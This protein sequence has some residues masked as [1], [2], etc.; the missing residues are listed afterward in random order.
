MKK[1]FPKIIAIVMVFAMALQFA[2]A[3]LAATATGTE[4]WTSGSY[5]YIAVFKKF[6]TT[7]TCAFKIT[8]TETHHNMGR[9]NTISGSYRVNTYGDTNFPSAYRNKLV[10]AAAKTGITLPYNHIEILDQYTIPASF[11]SGTYG[12][13]VTMIGQRGEYSVQKSYME[14]LPTTIHAGSFVCAPTS[15][16]TTGVLYIKSLDG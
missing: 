4:S 12:V 8:A 14:E 10:S 16:N 2:G 3:A 7:G 9:A 11:P 1:L 6:D 5:R 13:Q 15:C